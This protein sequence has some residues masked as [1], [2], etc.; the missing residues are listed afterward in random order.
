MVSFS[1]SEGLIWGRPLNERKTF[2][3]IQAQVL[4]CYTLLLVV[5]GSDE[6]MPRIRIDYSKVR[7]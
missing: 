1:L 6:K 2:V 7:T 5:T 4:I 3:K